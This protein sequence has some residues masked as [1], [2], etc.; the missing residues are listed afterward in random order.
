M[1]GYPV[2]RQG[3]VEFV[4]DF[5]VSPSGLVKEDRLQTP[6]TDFILPSPSSMPVVSRQDIVQHRRSCSKG[7]KPQTINLGCPIRSFKIKMPNKILLDQ[8]EDPSPF[9]FKGTVN[10][11]QEKRKGHGGYAE[12][13]CWPG[14][15][16]WM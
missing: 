4:S 2:K 16:G 14:G 13:D 5:A 9:P 8:G 1:P 11:H 15:T 7:D 6:V 10:E 12:E 3:T